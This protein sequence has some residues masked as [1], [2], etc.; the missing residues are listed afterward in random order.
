MRSQFWKHILGP[1]WP[2]AIATGTLLKHRGLRVANWLTNQPVPLYQW[3]IFR[4]LKWRYVNVPYVWPYFA[5]IFIP[6]HRPSTRPYIYI[7]GR[8]LQFRFLKWPLI[9]YIYMGI[10][11]YM[12]QRRWF[13]S[14][15]N[16]A[17]KTNTIGLNSMSPPKTNKCVHSSFPSISHH[18]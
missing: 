15:W 11:R 18:I 10:Y 1:S 6:L 9:I 8:Y 5:G 2:C 7:Y 17:K 16:S 14:F 4:I 12:G 13:C 3:E